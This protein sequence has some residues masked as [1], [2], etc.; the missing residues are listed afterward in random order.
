MRVLVTGG[1]G[2]IGSNLVHTLVASGH[3]VGVVDDLSSGKVGDLHPGAWFR[4]LDILDAAF[5]DAVRE[6]APEGV[7]H[8]AAQ[9]SV[10]DSFRDLARNH[11]VNVDGTRR[12]AR[13]ALAA[14]ARTLVS[15]SSAAVY[16]EPAELPLTETSPKAPANPYGDSK[17]QAELVLI[18]ELAASDV[19]FASFRFSNVYGPRQDSRGE[20]GVVAIFAG[21]M[22]ASEVPT[23]YG[24]GDQTRDF[25]FVGDVVSAIIDA[26]RTPDRLAV[27]GL[28]G[29]AYDISTGEEISVNDLAG[30][31]RAA[32]RYTGEVAHEP[33]RT[34]DVGRSALDPAKARRVFGWRAA[35][36]LDTGLETT[37]R[38][39]A[40]R[41]GM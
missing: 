21:R 36:P 12:V 35:V 22:T 28:D 18:E 31:M 23:I 5:V 9:P 2:F 10:S 34:G 29:P 25:I 26:L 16:G 15:A 24:T 39:F 14:E 3:D 33:A 40:S 8:L 13:A 37:I 19:D 7:V 1:A 11:A 20:G 41:P 32:A 4:R 27:E 38:W 17:L 6:F 30:R